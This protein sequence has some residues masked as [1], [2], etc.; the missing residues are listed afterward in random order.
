MYTIN[1]EKRQVVVTTKERKT[2]TLNEFD[3][4]HRIFLDKTEDKYDCD[5][6]LLEV[7]VHDEDGRKTTDTETKAFARRLDDKNWIMIF[8]DTEFM[9]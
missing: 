5:L 7:P 4:L 1:K 2:I 9:F 3:V 8:D 6:V